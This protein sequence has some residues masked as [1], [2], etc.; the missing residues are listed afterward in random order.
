MNQALLSRRQWLCVGGAALSGAIWGTGCQRSS[1]PT[2]DRPGDA[3]SGPARIEKRQSF[4]ID[5]VIDVHVHIVSS[6]M[7]G[8]PKEGDA[9]DQEFGETPDETA[10]IVGAQ[11]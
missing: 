2:P 5:E 11:M 1:G 9:E 6:N 4:D 7:P 3:K 10:R 8:V